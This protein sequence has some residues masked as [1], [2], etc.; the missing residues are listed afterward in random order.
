MG[1]FFFFFFFFFSSSSSSASLVQQTSAGQGR[2][3][4][5]VSRSHTMTSHCQ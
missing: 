3:N 5:K 1:F 4:N 2:L